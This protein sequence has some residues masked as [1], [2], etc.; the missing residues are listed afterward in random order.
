[1]T[2]AWWRS[3]GRAPRLIVY[4]TMR[5]RNPAGWQRLFW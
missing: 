2:Q 5:W 4:F 3:H 1:M